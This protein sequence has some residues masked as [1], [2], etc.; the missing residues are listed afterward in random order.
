MHFTK[1][2]LLVL[3]TVSCTQLYTMDNPLSSAVEARNEED[4]LKLLKEGADPNVK[5]RFGITPLQQAMRFT[6]WNIAQL[7]LEHKAD[8]NVADKDQGSRTPLH[9]AVLARKADLVNLL[10]K[11]GANPNTKDKDE[12]VPLNYIMD[13][14]YEGRIK[15][16]VALPI[17]NSLLE[18]K[19]DPDVEDKEGNLPL[20]IAMKNGYDKIAELLLVQGASPSV[21]FKKYYNYT[22]LHFAVD[23]KK[24]LVPFLI[25]MG[26]NP[27][28]KDENGRTPL[29]LAKL[30][31]IIDP[32]PA[33]KEVVEA[34]EAY[35]ASYSGGKPTVPTKPVK[36]PTPPTSPRVYSALA[37]ALKKLTLT[38]TELAQ[39]L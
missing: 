6:L 8:P 4:V 21:I 7:L 9:K 14:I 1:S 24:S 26:A 2:L 39:N 23:R 12:E 35:S 29:D 19:A 38:L 17:L 34:L 10:L 25:K 37:D 22:P 32:S 27:N 28:L 13:D 18:H 11:K 33:R 20:Y 30:K 15:E 16:D 3:L 31:D 36:Q 5:G